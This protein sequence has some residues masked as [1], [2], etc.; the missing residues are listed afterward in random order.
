[1]LKVR[2]SAGSYLT[3]AKYIPARRRRRAAAPPCTP[4]IPE[5]LELL[6]LELLFYF[7]VEIP[8]KGIRCRRVEAVTFVGKWRVV[9][10]MLL[11]PNVNVVFA[12]QPVTDAAGSAFPGWSNR[13]FAHQF[14]AIFRVTRSRSLSIH[15]FRHAESIDGRC[16]R[17]KA[18]PRVERRIEALGIL[19]QPLQNVCDGLI[20]LLLE[21]LLIQ[22]DDRL[23]AVSDARN[24]VTGYGDLL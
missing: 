8:P 1:M 13:F 7:H 10:K 16:A 18:L 19:R 20:P 4:R 3:R 5:L 21:E 11:M 12:S 23:R 2:G 9:S 17:R 22:S 24:K 14:F 6:L 15:F